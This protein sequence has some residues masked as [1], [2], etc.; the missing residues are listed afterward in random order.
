MLHVERDDSKAKFWLDPVR[1]EDNQGFGRRELNRIRK[2]VDENA[3]DLLRCWNEFFEPA[4]ED[5][6]S[7]ESKNN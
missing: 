3:D 2:L 5:G 7:P 6:D 4:D 1:L